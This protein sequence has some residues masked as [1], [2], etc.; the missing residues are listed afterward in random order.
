MLFHNIA[1]ILLYC[2]HVIAAMVSKRDLFKKKTDATDPKLKK[3]L[4]MCVYVYKAPI[5]NL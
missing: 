4:Q 1:V 3:K 5:I 2:D